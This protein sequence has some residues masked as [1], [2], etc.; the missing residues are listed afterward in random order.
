MKTIS[1]NNTNDKRGLTDLQWCNELYDYLQNKPLPEDTGIKGQSGIKLN[2][3]Q[4]FRV[5]WFLQEHLRILPDNIEQCDVCNELYDAHKSGLYI[6]EPYNASNHFC[7][8][9]ADQVPEK[10]CRE[11]Q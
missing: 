5:I 8:G 6:E 2:E 3:S 1:E 7:D 4:S 10:Y 9:C 11:E